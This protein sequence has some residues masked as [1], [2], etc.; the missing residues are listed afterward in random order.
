MPK[1]KQ[2][3]LNAFKFSKPKKRLH[4]GDS[5]ELLSP[6]PSKK[7]KITY[8]KKKRAPKKIYPNLYKK[9]R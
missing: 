8:P 5:D 2:N 1:K 9:K 7:E 4:L 6:S 3:K